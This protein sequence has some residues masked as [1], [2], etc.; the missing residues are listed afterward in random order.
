VEIFFVLLQVKPFQ[1]QTVFA[2]TVREQRLFLFLVAFFQEMALL[3]F[4]FYFVEV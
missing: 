1:K 4:L 3:F 2:T